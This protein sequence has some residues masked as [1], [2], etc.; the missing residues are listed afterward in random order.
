MHDYPC[1]GSKN[2]E[3]NNVHIKGRKLHGSVLKYGKL[4]YFQNV[5][6]LYL[7][8]AYNAIPAL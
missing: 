1:L 2:F 6:N 8:Q 4:A 3:K 5:V 7:P